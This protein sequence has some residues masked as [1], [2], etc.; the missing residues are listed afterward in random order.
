MLRRILATVLALVLI[1]VCLLPAAAT[2]ENSPETTQST[3]T[4]ESTEFTETADPLPQWPDRIWF[5]QLHAHT[6]LSES[7]VTLEATFARASREPGMDF[8]A[9]TDHSHSLDR[10]TEGAIALDGASV[11][12][13]WAAGK[14]AA[15]AVTDSSFVG[16]FGYEMSWPEGRQLGHISTFH[17]PG[18]ESR[19]SSAYEDQ[20]T[21]LETYYRAL[22]T[23]PGSVSQ[24]NHPG[25]YYGNFENFGHYSQEYDDRIH[26]LEV[27]GE[28]DST[29]YD[30][31]TKALD[32]GWHVAPSIGRNGTKGDIGRTAILA[33]SWR[34]C[35]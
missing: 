5:G 16:I 32:A 27:C 9:V 23:V 26:L 15:A 6:D 35:I 33:E 22:T 31:Y 13:K 14:A 20:T 17:T 18:W 2:E 21:A 34:K 19:N 28:G 10:D 11:S 30:A 12:T 7:T 3:E 25:S 8:F 4:T 24:F 1:L 29:F